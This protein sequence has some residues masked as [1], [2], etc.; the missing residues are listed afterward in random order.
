MIVT[1]LSMVCMP[2]GEKNKTKMNKWILC[3]SV[4]YMSSHIGL[5]IPN[6]E[7]QNKTKNKVNSQANYYMIMAWNE[8]KHK[9]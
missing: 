8:V 6:W 3:Y 5:I 1:Q 9:F 7:K 2:A 4:H